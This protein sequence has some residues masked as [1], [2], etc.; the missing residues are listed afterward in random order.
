MYIPGSCYGKYT[1][2]DSSFELTAAA[3]FFFF[4][5]LNVVFACPSVC[6]Q[7]LP[8]TGELCQHYLY[9]WPVSLPE[10]HPADGSAAPQLGAMSAF[11]QKRK[12]LVKYMKWH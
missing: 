7:P 1:S 11:L 4:L 3:F 2:L 9:S 10:L 12:N 8:E 5:P 6:S